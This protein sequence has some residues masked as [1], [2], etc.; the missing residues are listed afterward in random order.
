LPKSYKT[1]KIEGMRITQTLEVSMKIYDVN[2]AAWEGAVDE[3]TNLCTKVV[4][5]EQIAAARQGEWKLYL[6]EHKSVPKSWF[7]ELNGLIVGYKAKIWL[8]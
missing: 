4:S 6:S 1:G 2:K 8:K 7:P 5:S 3:G